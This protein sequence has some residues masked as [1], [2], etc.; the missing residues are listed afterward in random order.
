MKPS[1]F[2]KVAPG[3]RAGCVGVGLNCNAGKF[4]YEADAASNG[5]F[6]A[7]LKGEQHA[8]VIPLNRLCMDDDAVAGMVSDTPSPMECLLKGIGWVLTKYG[9][10]VDDEH[11][12][13]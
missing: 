13:K 3:G 10:K 6:T 7:H 9:L 4:Y 1:I 5:K 11:A 12:A 8:V 2:S